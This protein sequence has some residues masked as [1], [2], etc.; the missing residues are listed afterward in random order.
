[1]GGKPVCWFLM[2]FFIVFSI[3]QVQNLH[4]EVQSSASK[5]SQRYFTEQA[6]TEVIVPRIKL[7]AD[8]GQ[9]SSMKVSERKHIP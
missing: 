8:L 4:L 6:P 3:S 7:P 1:M 9:E 5:R 2:A